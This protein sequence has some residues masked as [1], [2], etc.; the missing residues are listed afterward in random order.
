MRKGVGALL[1]AG[2]ALTALPV[3]ADVGPPAHLRVSEREPG[4]FV[5]QW[6]VPKVLPPNAVPAPQLAETC[7]PQ[8]EVEIDQQAGAW[9][10]TRSWRCEAGLAGEVVGLRFPFADLA[11][12]T[13][14]RVDLLSGDRFAH[15]WSL[16]DDAWRLPC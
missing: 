11:L 2:L 9:L 6:R 14:I 10:F 8:G 1:I 3:L 13:V 16:G 12:T 15:V 7:V 4:V 5:T